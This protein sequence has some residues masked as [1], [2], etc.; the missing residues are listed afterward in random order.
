MDQLHTKRYSEAMCGSPVRNASRRLIVSQWA[1]FLLAFI[2]VVLRFTSRMPRFGGGI[3]WDDW[4]ILVVLIL[5]LAMN[6][7]SHIL[8]RFGAGQDI[9]MFEED[10][11]TSFLKYEFPEEYIYV[12][13][14]SLLKT[15][16]LL[17][18]LRVF[19]FRIQAY[20]LMGISA[21]YCTVFIVVSLASCQP[22]GYYFHR[23]NSQYSGTCLSI[24]NRVTASAIIN[25]IL[26]GVITLLPVTQV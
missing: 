24:S 26:D 16:V 8:L 19:N 6:V 5:S 25:I 21:C 15:S 7:L 23:W 1:L 22:F 18:Y 4:T 13:G 3:G 12:L 17:L 9:W 10:Q 2:S 14:V 11:L 20:I